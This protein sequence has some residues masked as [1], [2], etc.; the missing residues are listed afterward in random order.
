[1]HQRIFISVII[2][3]FA[4]G[5]CVNESGS[6]NCEAPANPPPPPEV[7]GCRNIPADQ[8]KSLG[9]ESESVTAVA[10][11]PN[12]E[13]LLLAGT[14][15]NFSDGN[16]GKL[17]R[18]TDCGQTWQI[19]IEGGSFRQVSFDPQSPN[20]VY[21]VNGS[22][23]KSTDYGANWDNSTDGIAL[24]PENGVGS[25]AINPKHSC[26][27][28][29]GSSGFTGGSLYK[30]TDGGASW[31]EL[32]SNGLKKDYLK[33]GVVSL[34]ID[35]NQT[36]TIYAGTSFTGDVLKSTNGGD[37][38][39]A[40]GLLETGSIIYDLAI[41]PNKTNKIYAGLNR[42][43]LAA[44]NNKGK[45]WFTLDNLIPDSINVMKLSFLQNKD[46][47]IAITS[48]ADNG[49]IVKLNLNNNQALK[50]PNP[51][52]KSYFYSDLQVVN[53]SNQTLIFFGLD[54]VFVKKNN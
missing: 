22:V 4:V 30:S 39:E 5:S 38:W 6:I 13:G 50:L 27:L 14:Q 16:T 28:Y 52:N 12:Y 3:V 31:N 49:N 54:G 24:D 45:S 33:N 7:T 36:N 18:S 35:P 53:H 44:S 47:L 25:L 15:F 46:E 34:A 51:I 8:W 42:Q 26:V 40:T 29:A 43:G 32:K 23:L 21:A 9:L 11:H 1:M 20:I 10:A 41:S 2:V 37:S 17:Y 48:I 19:E